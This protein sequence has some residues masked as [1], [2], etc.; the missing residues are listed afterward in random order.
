MFKL[1]SCSSLF[2]LSESSLTESPHHCVHPVA[3]LPARRALAAALV[4]VEQSQ[5][6]NGLM[7][8]KKRFT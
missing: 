7:K 6:G 1:H 4:L 3:A 5:S 2:I 8:G